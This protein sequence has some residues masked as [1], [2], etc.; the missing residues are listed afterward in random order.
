[1][2]AIALVSVASA[3]QLIDMKRIPK[4]ITNDMCQCAEGLRTEERDARRQAAQNQC[5]SQYGLQIPDFE[6]EVK[7]EIRKKLPRGLA[8][9]AR[10][11]V[12]TQGVDYKCLNRLREF[13]LYQTKIRKFLEDLPKKTQDDYAICF[14][15]EMKWLTPSGDI[16]KPFIRTEIA[17]SPSLN[18]KLRQSLELLSL[19]CR[20]KTSN[21][22]E[23]YVKCAMKPCL[24]PEFLESLA[25]KKESGA[26]TA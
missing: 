18:P 22:L 4:K 14:G 23:T 12:E 20:G 7:E 19:T 21:E 6:T 11:Q 3:Q 17:G 15:K 8:Q 24:E 2:I 26:T 16:D 9:W 10:K 25:S 13:Y 5:S 1:M